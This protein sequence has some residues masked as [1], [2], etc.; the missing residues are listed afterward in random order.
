MLK[1]KLLLPVVAS[2]AL[3]A[4]VAQADT[5]AQNPVKTPESG[6]YVSGGVGVGNTHVSLGGLSGNAVSTAISADLGY[7]FNKYVAMGANSIFLV[8]NGQALIPTLLYVKGILPL[9]ERFNMYAKLG[10]GATFETSGPAVYNYPGQFGL[11]ASYQLTHALAVG[12]EADEIFP[13][14]ENFMTNQKTS[15]TTLTANVTYYF[16]S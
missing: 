9:S 3:L 8:R 13:I 4:S 7:K 6:F 12:V 15:F 2:I 10:G 14:V 1:N 5:Q 11:G 16:G